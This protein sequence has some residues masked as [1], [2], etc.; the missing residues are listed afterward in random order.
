MDRAVPAARP[1]L[2]DPE[3]LLALD[4]PSL[5]PALS[6]KPQGW[7]SRRLRSELDTI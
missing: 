7:R 6:R 4:H 1:R 5:P 2:L 3:V